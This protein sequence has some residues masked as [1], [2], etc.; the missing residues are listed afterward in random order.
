MATKS[1][2]DDLIRPV[3]SIQVIHYVCPN[4]QEEVEE[5][6][7]CKSCKAPMRVMQVKELYGEEAQKFL[8]DL[9]K[10][11]DSE[12]KVQGGLDVDKIVENGV[13]GEDES[14]EKIED[15]GLEQ[16][17][18]KP[19]GFD[20]EV[21]AMFSEGGIFDDGDSD[22]GDDDKKAPSAY[23]ANDPKIKELIEDLDQTE[24]LLPD[25]DLEDFKQIGEL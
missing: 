17:S 4:C 13:L 20:D 23:N 6:R 5:A 14:L 10:K 24:S 9:R 22:D 11:N 7:I 25:D 21:V 19:E 18:S 15:M 12:I 1:N 3:V 2:N 16:S 8:E